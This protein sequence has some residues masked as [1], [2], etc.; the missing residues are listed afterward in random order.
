MQTIANQDSIYNKMG[1]KNT[2]NSGWERQ[3]GDGECATE[4]KRVRD[5]H[6][7]LERNRDV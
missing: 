2:H 4:K 5:G 7:E 6:K 3:E 1:R